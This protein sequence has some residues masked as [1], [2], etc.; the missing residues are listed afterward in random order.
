MNVQ[1]PAKK[2]IVEI[3]GYAPN[4]TSPQCRTLWQLGACPFISMPCTKRNHDSTIIYGTCSVTTSYGDCIICPHRLYANDF[5]TL[6]MVALEVFGNL[7]F[8]TYADY[9]KE[10][11][12][13]DAFVVALGMHSGHEITLNR[14]CSMDWVLVKIENHQLV[15]YTGIEVQSIDITGNYRDNWYAY[16]NISENITIP[17]SEHGLN[18]ANVYKRL[19]PQIIRKSLIYSRSSFVHCGLHFIVPEIVYQ[20]FE[21]VIGV[22]IPLVDKKAPNVITVH[23]YQ[24]GRIVPEG[25]IRTIELV[26][27]IRFKIEEFSHRFITGPNLPTVTE[28]DHAIR[29]A[30][31]I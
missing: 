27:N 14:T 13:S 15:E 26:R 10:R 4:D 24:L 21:E 11:Q 8:Y 6:K 17:K 16:K 5:Q 12:R 23:T 22:D 2:D 9:I 30:L 3:F 25:T 20:K 31:G 18:W 28:L 29:S 7:P 1:R 19:I